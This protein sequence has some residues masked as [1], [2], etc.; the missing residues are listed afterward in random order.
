MTP[1]TDLRAAPAPR[2]AARDI[3]DAVLENLRNNLE[4][5][6][7]T[8]LAPSRFLVYLHPTEFERIEGI[9][10]ILEKET[11]RA[12]TD[13]LASLNRRP[14]W[15]RHVDR[16]LGVAPEV[17]NA[18]VEWHVEFLRDPDGELQ[19]GDILIDSEL[20]LPPPTDLGA[21]ERTRRV[22]TRHFERRPEQEKPVA[23]VPA[24]LQTPSAPPEPTSRTVTLVETL[25]RPAAA[26]PV[27]A[28]LRY[29]DNSGAHTYDIARDSVTVGRG[30]MAYRVDVRVEASADVSREHL[31]LRRDPATGR[32]YVVDLSSLG[33][34]VDG[35]RVPKGYE[36]SDG[37]KRENGV[38]TALPDR[39]RLGLADT[40][41]VDFETIRS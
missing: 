3:I 8:V 13:E 38:E 36:E 17:Q 11:I 1:E 26:S 7:Y 25:E 18:A 30:G 28:R 10:P 41:Y 6:K 22:T 37:S 4:P 35:R 23:S 27:L 12:L 19:E 24:V 33:T 34:T 29:E 32:F 20:L 39:A 16:F 9:V 21:G 5:L 31:R 40:V 14:A 15:R 2:R